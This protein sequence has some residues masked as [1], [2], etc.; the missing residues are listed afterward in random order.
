MGVTPPDDKP[1]ERKSA[2]VFTSG[3]KL[4]PNPTSGLLYADF[5]EWAGENLQVQVFG[6]QGQQVRLQTL[7]AG[8]TPQALDLPE[9]LSAGMYFLE[10]RRENGEKHTQRFIKSY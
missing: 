8:D 2:T 3:M 1:A 4:F 5:S 9:S 6:S 7:V 10:V